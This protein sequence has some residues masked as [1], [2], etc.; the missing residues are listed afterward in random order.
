MNFSNGVNR[1]DKLTPFAFSHYLATN[2]DIQTQKP[3]QSVGCFPEAQFVSQPSSLP[4]LCFSRTPFF[5]QPIKYPPLVSD[6]GCHRRIRL[7]VSP[8]LKNSVGFNIIHQAPTPRIRT[9]GKGYT[10][11]SRSRR[12]DRIPKFEKEPYAKPHHPSPATRVHASAHH[13][14]VTP[15]KAVETR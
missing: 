2:K 3:E 7:R 6:A 13:E 12:Q 15:K 8:K 1:G 9:S 11:K 5:S 4:P 10:E 14:K